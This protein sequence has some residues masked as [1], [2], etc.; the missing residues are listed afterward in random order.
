MHAPG[1]KAEPTSDPYAAAARAARAFFG[2]AYA[3]E[4]EVEHLNT[5]YRFTFR[6]GSR[7]YVVEV[8]EAAQ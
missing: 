3:G 2:K 6:K 7:S 8:L 1:F 5:G 4:P